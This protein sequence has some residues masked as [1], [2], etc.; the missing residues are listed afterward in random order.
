MK[1]QLLKTLI[2]NGLY[3]HSVYSKNEIILRSKCYSQS[4]Y[5]IKE[6]IVKIMQITNEG[7]EIVPVLLSTGQVFGNDVIYGDFYS[8]YTSES[9]CE[10]T[11]I[12][13]FEINDIQLTINKDITFHKDLLSLLKEEHQQTEKRIK[14][15]RI[16]SAEERLIQ[17]FIEFYYKFKIPSNTTEHVFIRSPLTQNELAAYTRTSRVTTNN[18]INHLK[19]KS[20]IEYHNRDI[21]LKK[22]F[23]KYYKNISSRDIV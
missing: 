4:I 21:V 15:L 19:N 12:Y 6:G 20:L 1:T 5:F 13:E 22:A 16:R 8:S 18:I 7:E 2:K 17:T 14:S 10:N 11:S 3:K 23:F 9:L